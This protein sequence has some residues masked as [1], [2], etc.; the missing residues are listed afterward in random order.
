MDDG[1]PLWSERTLAGTPRP[2][3]ALRR[4]RVRE[5]LLNVGARLF[6]AEGV[7]NVSVE[8]VIASANI[9]RS[10]FY[11]FFDSKRD[12]LTHIVEPVF[13]NGIAAMRALTGQ[14]PRAMLSGVIDT[15]LAM[16]ERQADALLLSTRLARADFGLVEAAHRAFDEALTDVLKNVQSAGL[17]RNG[18]VDYTRKLIAKSAVETLL[19]YQGD[20]ELRRLYRSTMEGMLLAA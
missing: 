6:V 20:S 15:Y 17:L 5:S 14:S 7:E 1:S 13:T 18:S 3:V 16:W 8:D 11:T 12:L 10:T 4:A 19:V 2:R 9:A